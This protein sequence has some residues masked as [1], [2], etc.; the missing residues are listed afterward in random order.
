[1]EL[2]VLTLLG[3]KIGYA[4]VIISC[5]KNFAFSFLKNESIPIFFCSVK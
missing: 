2:K 4:D 1:M 3:I 5:C